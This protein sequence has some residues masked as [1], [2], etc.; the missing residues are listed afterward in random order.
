MTNIVTNAVA[1]ATKAVASGGTNIFG[2][3]TV[4][5]LYLAVIAFLGFKGYKATKNSADYMVGGRN[6]HPYIMALSYGATFISTSAIVGFGGFASLFGMSL[7]WL[8]VLNI[9]I[10]ILVAFVVF[11]KRTRRMGLNLDAHTFPEFLGKRLDSRFIQWFSGAVIFI[12]MPLYAA[13]V[14]IGA[15]RIMESMLQIPY[16]IA[17]AV[18]SI[19]VAAYVIFGGLKGVMYTDALQG[20]LMFLGMIALLIIVYSKLGG[21]VPAHEA[22]TNLKNLV[23]AKLA[24]AGHLGWTASPA[25]GSPFWWVVYSSIVLGV[26]IGVLAQPQL[27]VRFMTVKS[28]KELNRAVLIGGVFILVTVG[29]PFIVGALS[30]VYFHGTLGKISLAVAKGNVDKVIPMFINSATPKWFG[31]L[32]M[33]VI[34][35]AAMSTLSSQFHTIGTSIGRD[36]YEKGILKGKTDKKKKGREIL[37]TRIG[38]V[39]SILFT[40]FLGLILGKGVIARATAIFF[41]VMASSFLAPYALSLYWKKLTRKGAIAGIISGISTSALWFLFVHAKEAEVFGVCQAI[42]GKK[43]LLGGLWPVVDAIVI[44]LPISILFTVIISLLTK[45]ENPETVKKS[46][47]G[48]GK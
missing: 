21:V 41:G 42:F 44:A 32:F 40:V 30:N 26:G 8:T 6:I 24:G 9:G 10:G 37:I 13:A 45:V 4:I 19:L 31:Y 11:G 25:G 1:E 23:P 7:L 43:V 5:V 15:S 34:L 18:F 48:I 39:V 46:F 16:E 14:L 47:S 33:L 36:V 17:V 12:L 27:V 38:I 2:M 20:T 3:I 29:T 22:L 35:S 28:N